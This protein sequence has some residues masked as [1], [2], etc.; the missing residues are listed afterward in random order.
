MNIAEKNIKVL[1]NESIALESVL[2]KLIKLGLSDS[3][4]FATRLFSHGPLM[5]F[6]V[7]LGIADINAERRHRLLK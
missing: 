7:M 3:A 4:K 6:E 2:G 5:L 1:R